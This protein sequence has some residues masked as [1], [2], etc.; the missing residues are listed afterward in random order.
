MPP[1]MAD[2]VH[3]GEQLE[4]YRLFGGAS[5][6][7]VCDR[8]DEFF[9][10]PQKRLFEVLQC[11]DSLFIRWNG[12][13]PFQALRLEYCDQR[14]AS[15]LHTKYCT[16][17]VDVHTRVVRATGYHYIPDAAMTAAGERPLKVVC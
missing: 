12:L 16:R 14:F 1:G 7:I 17:F 3:Y 8:A 4:R 9:L 13:L 2:L 10:A 5:P 15:G 11:L 6:E